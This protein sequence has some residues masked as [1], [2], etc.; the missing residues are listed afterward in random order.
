MCSRRK[1][2]VVIPSLN[3]GDFLYQAIESVLVQD[4]KKE[5]IV[6]DGG[7][8]D[9]S[10]D[11]IKS[12]GQDI[13]FWK[14]EKDNGQSASINEGVS[15]GSGD[16]VLWINSDDL[17]LKDSLKVS[18][19]YFEAYPFAPFTYGR[20]NNLS[21]I[22]KNQYPVW[23]EPFSLKRLAQRCI[24]S[25]PGTVIRRTCWEGVSGLDESLFMAMDYDL[26]WRLILKYSS[27]VFVDSL[28]AIN[29]EHTQ[30]KTRRFRAQHYKEAIHVVRKYTGKVPLKWWLAQP[31]SVWFKTL[32]AMRD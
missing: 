32:I 1:F 3:Q 22:S 17:L 9:N 24:I 20:V 25:Q 12:F 18:E 16:Y 14:S 4:V 21:E 15:L 11:I 28:L 13:Y 23:V 29:R 7:S 27:P 19:E 30:T 2:T 26:W 6:M 10:V 8:T 31:Y 5:V